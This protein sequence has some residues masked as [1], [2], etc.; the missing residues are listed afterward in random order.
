M[1][2]CQTA[3]K[4]T[5]LDR[6]LE[7]EEDGLRDEDLTGLGAKVADLSLEELDLLSRARA[8]DLKETVYDRVEVD[9]VLVRHFWRRRCGVIER[10]RARLPLT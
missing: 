2:V 5:Y 4:F 3:G 8:A 9:I 1:K 10:D 6:S 7:F